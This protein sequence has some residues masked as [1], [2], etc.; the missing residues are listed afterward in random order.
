MAAILRRLDNEHVRAIFECLHDG[1]P[2]PPGLPF[3]IVHVGSKGLKLSP[4]SFEFEGKKESLVRLFDSNRQ[5]GRAH[6]LF[7]SQMACTFFSNPFESRLVRR[8]LNHPK[9]LNI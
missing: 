2:P 3:Q 1:K 6:H 4:P 5:H 8:T 9:F 7:V